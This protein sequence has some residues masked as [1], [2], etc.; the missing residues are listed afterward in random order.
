[1]PQ[2]FDEAEL[3]A[4]IEDTLD[5]KDAQR[6][7]RRLA[8]EPEAVA[9]IERMREDRALLRSIPEPE[10]PGGLLAELEPILAR[11]M[12]M[13]ELPAR[14]RRRP[15]LRSAVAAAVV[16]LSLGGF[17]AVLISNVG[18]V[19]PS[20]VEV[21]GAVG[22]PV[23]QPPPGPSP[24]DSSPALAKA[25]Q[26]PWPPSGSVIHHHAPLV[27]VPGRT[28]V[29]GARGSAD[30]APRT[31]DPALVAADFM[32]VVRAH[33]EAEAQQT[34][35]RIVSDLGTETALVRNFTYGEADEIEALRRLAEGARPADVVDP[36]DTVAEAVGETPSRR[37]G[38]RGTAGRPRP[39]PRPQDLLET[40]FTRSELL[41]GSSEL[42]P[43]FAR[44]LDFSERGAVYTLSVPAAR[45]MQVLA[46]LQLDEERQTWLRVD[47][48][49]SDEMTDELRWLRD[50]PLV[51]QAAATLDTHG[52]GAIILL[53]VVVEQP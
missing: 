10:V 36:A 28:I 27:D 39:R 35:Q 15:P 18:P 29:A 14:R 7:T 33:D 1:M 16:L 19:A 4:L 17:W 26:G 53:P 24:I 31:G 22:G 30:S 13:P 48:A 32:L 12:L 11:P 47:G 3:L 43:S 52:R 37:Q 40:E 21:A 49:S 20:P 42:A 41:V 5:P 2:R 6:L 23:H 46:R 45:L 50:W 51:K 9:L 38:Q 8:S 25:F 44:Q 34:L